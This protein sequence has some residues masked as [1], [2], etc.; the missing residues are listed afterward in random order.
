MLGN[1]FEGKL[2]SFSRI[3]ASILSL[4]QMRET[5]KLVNKSPDESRR[6]ADLPGPRA[7]SLPSFVSR[8]RV[9]REEFEDRAG[10]EGPA[11]ARVPS[12]WPSATSS[13]TPHI[14]HRSDYLRSCSSE[15]HLHSTKSSGP[16]PTRRRRQRFFSISCT[17]ATIKFSVVEGRR[18]EARNVVPG[19]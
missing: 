9:Q 4:Q 16:R 3:S 18:G 8:R 7:L 15:E 12:P 10:L 2:L 1:V 6:L 17:R 14:C 13:S 5:L 19:H 11:H